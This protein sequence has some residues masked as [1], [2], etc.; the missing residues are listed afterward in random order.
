MST[1]P[2]SRSR[3]KRSTTNLGDLRLAPLSAK[4]ADDS[5]TTPPAVKT[6]TADH[7]DATFSRQHPSYLQGKSAPTTPGILSRSSSRKHLVGGGLSRKNSLYNDD[8]DNNDEYDEEVTYAYTGTRD[9]RKLRRGSADTARAIPKSN[10]EATLLPNK[11]HSPTRRYKYPV[12]RPRTGASTPAAVDES[13]LS[14][15]GATASALVQEGKG[16]SWLASREVVARPTTESEEE[17][18]DDQYEEM[19]ALSASTA[20]LHFAPFDGGSP[21]STRVSRWGSRYGSRNASRRTS[22]RASPSAGTRTPRPGDGMGYFDGHEVEMMGRMG[23][24]EESSESE[25]EIEQL[26]EGSFGLGPLVDRLMG[27]NPFRGDDGVEST[28]DEGYMGKENE[29][30]DEALRQRSVELKRRRDEKAKLAAHPPPAPMGQG[31]NGEGEVGGWSD[32]A[33]LLSVATKAM[34]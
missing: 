34:F 29:G 32:A 22:R 9:P 31:G 6:P 19:A 27:F 7:A 26:G 8:D 20:Q 28:D 25:I 30:R 16:Q 12:R 33:W 5:N 23:K 15:A 3:S 21:V 24:G 18:D 17:E 11:P 1:T 13:W 2:R 10:S 4:F 14:H